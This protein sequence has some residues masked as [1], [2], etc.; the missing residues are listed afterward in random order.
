LHNM[1]TNTGHNA[2][3]NDNLSSVTTNDIICY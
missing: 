2:L 1:N 3:Q